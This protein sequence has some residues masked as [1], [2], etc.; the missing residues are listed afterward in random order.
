MFEIIILLNTQIG[1]NV[2][3]K[4]WDSWAAMPETFWRS[5]TRALQKDTKQNTTYDFFK[6]L[7]KILSWLKFKF[8]S[9]NSIICK[10]LAIS[11]KYYT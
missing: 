11:Y 5:H 8:H 3:E 2:T 9:I 1:T 10:Y 6:V 4:T 7:S